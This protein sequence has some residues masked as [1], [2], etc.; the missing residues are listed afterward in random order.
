MRKTTMV[1]AA[2][3]LFGGTLI[4]PARGQDS[5]PAVNVGITVDQAYAAIPH[6]HIVWDDSHS[7]IPQSGRTYLGT[8]FQ[9]I[10]EAV[11]LR[12]AGQLDFSAGRFDSDDIVGQFDELI[13]YARGLT[14]P[15]RL[16]YYHRY[17]VRCLSSERKVF[18]DW[19]SQQTNF[20]YAQDIAKDPD[21][22]D[23]SRAVHAAY[24]CLVLIYPNETRNNKD[25][26]YDYHC[27]LDF[28]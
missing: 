23:A 17:I 25:A 27:A 13:A 22:L 12:V 11:E 9:V 15:A 3:F 24:L 6:R 16:S 20:P 8:M 28:L 5:P 4:R 19:K 2:V 7:P 1:L 26:F 10:D 14:V 21:V 18:A